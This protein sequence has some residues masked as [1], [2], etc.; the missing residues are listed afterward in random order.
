MDGQKELNSES[1]I[2]PAIPVIGFLPELNTKTLHKELVSRV[3]NIGSVG[4]NSFTCPLVSI[5]SKN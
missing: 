1:N 4:I 2:S 3:D 5:V